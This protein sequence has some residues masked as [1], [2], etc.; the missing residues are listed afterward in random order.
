VRDVVTTPAAE[1]GTWFN[2]V[3]TQYPE[4]VHFQCDWSELRDDMYPEFAPPITVP[5]TETATVVFS[6]WDPEYAVPCAS[7][8]CAKHAA[9]WESEDDD[10]YPTVAPYTRL[11]R[12]ADMDRA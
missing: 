11:D 5:C 1:H 6:Y 4:P 7:K 10:Q 12:P 8:F 9:I 3:T 2:G